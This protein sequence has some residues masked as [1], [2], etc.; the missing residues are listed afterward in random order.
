MQ[1]PHLNGRAY[2]ALEREGMYACL[3]H[4]NGRAYPALEREGMYAGPPLE[5]E[6]IPGIPSPNKY[7]V[8]GTSSTQILMKFKI[9]IKFCA[10]THAHRPN[11]MGSRQ[12][13]VP[14]GLW[15]HATACEAPATCLQL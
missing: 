10:V 6:G 15:E 13:H 2:P 11:F 9:A 4:L 5:R 7:S 1:A 8:D 3:S 14:L 12:V